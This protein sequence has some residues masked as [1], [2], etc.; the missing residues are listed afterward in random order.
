MPGLWTHS[1]SPVTFTICVNC[2]GVNYIGNQHVDHLMTVLSSHYT[3]SRY[4]TCSRY[5]GIDLYWDYEK[6][7]VHLSMLSYVKDSLTRFPHS[8]PHKPQHQ[9]YPHAK[10]T[11]GYKAQYA[12]A[13]DDY[14][15]LSP[16]GK[17]S[18]KKYPEIFSTTSAALTPQ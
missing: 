12:T 16:T 2:F 3:I 4:W 9:P 14:L 10:L 8:R 13:D 6:R 11:Y 5:L 17:N 15:L 18:S 1:W 7:E